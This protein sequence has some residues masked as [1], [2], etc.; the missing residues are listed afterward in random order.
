MNDLDTA[1]NLVD[2][3]LER[4]R[5]RGLSEREERF[6]RLGDQEAADKDEEAVRELMHQAFEGFLDAAAEGYTFSDIDRVEQKFGRTLPENYPEAGPTFLPFARA[7]WTFQFAVDDLSESARSTGAS[8]ILTEIEHLVRVLFFPAYGPAK[9]DPDKREQ[10]QRRMLA[11][12]EKIDTDQFMAENP[13]LIRDRQEMK[14]GCLG[15]V[16]SLFK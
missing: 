12:C 3:L 6:I 15:S 10:D 4:G 14:S 11:R 9:V 13:I 16:R 5:G 8:N 7:Y 2:S 1:V